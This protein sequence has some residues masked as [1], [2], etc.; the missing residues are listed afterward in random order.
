MELIQLDMQVGAECQGMR[1]D[2]ILAKNFPQYSRMRL[3]QWIKQGQVLVDG[4]I[5]EPKTKLHGGEYV[6]IQ[7]TVPVSTEDMPQSI[8][9]D[10]L[11]EDDDLLVL[12]KPAGLVVHPGAGNTQST[13]LNALLHHAPS[14]QHLPRAGIVHRLD[15]DTTGLMVVAKSLPAHTGLVAALQAR[16]I[17]R[18]YLALIGSELIAG[19]TVDAPIARHPAQRTKMAVDSRGKPAVTHYRCQRR[20]QGFTLLKV[21][22]ETGRTHQI[23]VHLSHKNYPIVGDAL[24]GWRYKIPPQSS[25]ALQEALRAFRRQ[26]LHA[27]RLAFIHPVTGQALEW[28]T[29]LPEDF[30]HLLTLL[31]PKENYYAAKD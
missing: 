23:R 4:Q 19:G 26:A 20:Y 27:E 12:N 6:A 18:E 8:P 14:L 10:I 21:R 28:Q 16:E 13:L 9:L 5:C 15:K 2:Q 24:Y 22:L 7:A 3:S 30:A 11:Y 29:P 31:T 25:Q 1:L 17:Q